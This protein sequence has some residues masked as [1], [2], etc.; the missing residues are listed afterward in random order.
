MG[1]G[2]ARAA[3]LGAA[4]LMMAA[5]GCG[6]DDDPGAPDGGMGDAL[7]ADHEAVTFFAAVQP[8]TRDHLRQECA[9]YYGHTSHGSQI[10]TGLDLLADEDA[11]WSPPA[12]H[13]VGDDLGHLGDVSW[14]APTRAWLDAHPGAVDVVMWS[15]CGGV[16]DNT[17]AGIQAYLD[18][19]GT[20]EA[21]YPG[22]VFV[23]MTGHLDG[24]G[25]AGNLFAR[26]EQIR[27]WCRDHGKVLFD[28]ADIETWDPDGGYHPDDTDACNWCADWCATHDCPDCASSCAHSRCLN[29]YLKGQAFWVL[30]ARL[31]AEGRV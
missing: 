18:A 4:L 19:M 27:A 17:P 16:S 24:T 10:V 11:A 28:F 7:V 6:G 15:W 20:L 22:V 9:I 31:A 26:N 5:T 3:L 23:Y 12:I 2:T 25:E 1:N 30:L 29:C 21:D 13:E 14:V 8:A